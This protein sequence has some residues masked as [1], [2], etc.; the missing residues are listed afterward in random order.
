MKTWTGGRPT[1][2]SQLFDFYHSYVK[3]L[4]SAVQTQNTL[5]TETLFELNAAFDHMARHWSYG[6]PEQMAVSEAFGHLKRSCLDI[7][8]LKVKE[9]RRQYVIL[10][11]LDTSTIDNGKYDQEL[12]RLFN[13]IRRDATEAR[14]AESLDDTE[15]SVPAF[16]RWEKVYVECT[17][18]ETEFFSHESLNWAKRKSLSRFI[19]QNLWGM[20]IGVVAALIAALIWFYV[21]TPLLGTHL[22]P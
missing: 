3:L 17:R 10:C 5:P 18:L 15:G 8:K 22:V 16:E 13:S 6:V 11:A 12:H 20:L 21:F 4:Y 1:T 19:R 2:F 9:A 14:Q 7:F